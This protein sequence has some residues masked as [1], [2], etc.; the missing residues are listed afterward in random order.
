[1]DVILQ[2]LVFSAQE[3]IDNNRSIKKIESKLESFEGR[4]IYRSSLDQIE[5]LKKENN[6]R[7]KEI[8]LEYKTLQSYI[9]NSNT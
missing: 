1:M 9:E 3:I 8:D 5:R 6:E 4:P 7:L 2:G